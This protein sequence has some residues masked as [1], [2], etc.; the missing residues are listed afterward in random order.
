MTFSRQSLIVLGL[1]IL[2]LAVLFFSFMETR[3]RPIAPA[4]KRYSFSEIMNRAEPRKNTAQAVESLTESVSKT[5]SALVSGEKTDAQIEAEI[6]ALDPF[7]KATEPGDYALLTKILADNDACAFKRYQFKRADLVRALMN[8]PDAV[9][10][11]ADL[12]QSMLDLFDTGGD[13]SQMVSTQNADRSPINSFVNALFISGQLSGASPDQRDDQYALSILE[14]LASQD[15]DNGAYDYFTILPMQRAGYSQEA[16][17]ERFRSMFQKP[18]FNTFLKELYQR[19]FQKSLIDSSHFLAGLLINRNSPIPDLSGTRDVLNGFLKQNDPQF[20]SEALQ[21]A[22][23]LMEEPTDTHLK[24]IFYH[25]DVI[26][27]QTGL[28]IARFSWPPDQLPNPFKG[29]P[30]RGSKFMSRSYDLNKKVTQEFKLN[31]SPQACN[32]AGLEEF[33]QK[34][35]RTYIEDLHILN[36]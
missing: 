20:N 30:S 2:S 8:T 10:V 18:V 32:Q 26:Q 17:Q 7:A 36:R 19:M 15:P 34:T 16:I 6:A 21:F 9:L 13:A 14:N 35:K 24:Y 27:Y 29:W 33:V 3:T 23:V 11:N 22:K 28:S 12:D 4:R 5:P 31:F 1:G 25:W